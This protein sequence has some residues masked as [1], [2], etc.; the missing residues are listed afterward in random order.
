LATLLAACQGGQDTEAEEALPNYSLIPKNGWTEARDGAGRVLALVPR[1]SDIQT[2]LPAHQVI[3][4]PVQRIVAA[5]GHYDVGIIDALGRLPV[6]I[7]TDEPADTWR[8]P[9]IR[10][11][12]ESGQVPFVGYW[13]ALDHEAIRGLAPDLTLTSSVEV[14]QKLEALG[15][16]VAVTYNSFDNGFEN[17]LRLF[18]FLGALVSEG[19]RA[20]TL[21][22][23]LRRTINDAAE[24]AGSRPRPKVGWGVFF[25][26]RVY[27]LD[28]DFWLAEIFERCGGDY[29]M[30]DIRSGMMELG[31]ED[32]L[33]KN[34]PAEIYFASLLHEGSVS[35]KAE[36][37]VLHPELAKVKAFGPGGRVYSPEELV[38]Q[39]TGRLSDIISEVAAII[40]PELYPGAKAK[41][42]R[43]LR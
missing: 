15:Y 27:A 13:D 19:K 14:G 37:L 3:E 34:A 7:A 26:N 2:G 8:V 35:T 5:S 18:G 32:F 42:F 31:L 1:G 39:D 41:Y 9:D 25:N 23:E 11:H 10:A 43:E 17:R 20:E 28:G 36:Y 33:A 22:D 21:V 6:I 29:V 30:G 38:F 24:A 4:V 12:V 40:H 16:K